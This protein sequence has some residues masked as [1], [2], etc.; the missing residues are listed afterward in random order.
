MHPP[1]TPESSG[2]HVPSTQALPDSHHMIS[3]SK[4]SSFQQKLRKMGLVVC[5]VC[6]AAV[7]R[8]EEWE[9]SLKRFLGLS[10]GS[11]EVF[12]WSAIFS[13]YIQMFIS[14]SRR[15]HLASAT[16]KQPTTPNFQLP[17]VHVCG[18]LRRNDPK[19]HVFACLSIGTIRRHGLTG[20]STTMGGGEVLYAQTMTHVA[21]SLLLLPENQNVECSAL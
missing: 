14:S 2:A 1:L 19:I 6:D 10:L 16:T 15:K 3:A 5:P 8:D 9:C 21:L 18:D 4:I 7:S 17:W 20:G 12:S 13:S 11:S